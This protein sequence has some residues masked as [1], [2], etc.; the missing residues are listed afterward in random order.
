MKDYYKIL[1][2]EKGASTDEVKKAYR[3]LA[4]RYHPD[5]KG[6][7]SERFKEVNEAYQILSDAN[8]RKQYDAFGTTDGFGWQGGNPFNG[9]DFDASGMVDMEDIFDVFFG[10]GFQGKRKSYKRGSDLQYITQITL[11]EA[12]NGIRKKI[13][14]PTQVVC[15]ECVGKGFD[16]N[17]GVDICNTCGGRGEIKETRKTFFGSFAK[18]KECHECFGTGEK[19]KSTCAKCSGSGKISGEREVEVDILPGVAQGQIIKVAGFGEAGERAASA[20]DLYIKIDIK[21][22]NQFERRGDD[23]FMN[24]NLPILD[25]LS[26]S[27]I[28]VKTIAGKNIII[29]IPVGFN[30]NESL[31]VS[32]QGMPRFGSWGFGNLIISFT[33][34]TPKKISKK[35]QELIDRLKKEI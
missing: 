22:H 27:D 15:R 7:S 24:I 30:L 32:D 1:G 17:K 34:L 16:K 29:S 18:V 21:N 35:A 9:F 10:G 20:G 3:K 8:K 2:L 11:E 4:H 5:K 25:V 33:V 19:P 12:Y 23:L 6:G 14:F 26:G 31:T 28:S 13:K